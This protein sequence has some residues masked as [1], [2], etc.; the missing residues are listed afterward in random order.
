MCGYIRVIKK[1][2]GEEQSSPVIVYVADDKPVTLS[3]QVSQAL[4]GILQN[5]L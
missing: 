4:R 1:K 2:T 3:A 5:L